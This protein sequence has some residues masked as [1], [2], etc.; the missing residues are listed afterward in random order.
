MSEPPSASPIRPIP[1]QKC[2]L[3]R[4]WA[5]KLLGT[6]VALILV[7]LFLLFQAMPSLSTIARVIRPENEGPLVS[8]QS[9]ALQSGKSS[10]P[11]PDGPE[12]G[13]GSAPATPSPR[14]SSRDKWSVLFSDSSAGGSV[15]SG[16]PR[17]RKFR[18]V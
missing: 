8:T 6:V 5:P 10:A 9:R 18:K 17:L 11:K 13:G 4:K 14:A 2:G 12:N 16:C 1:A 7:A 15:P 3:L